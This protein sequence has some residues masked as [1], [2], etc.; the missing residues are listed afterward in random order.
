MATLGERLVGGVGPVELP[1]VSTG[2]TAQSLRAA[3]ENSGITCGDL[4]RR[5]LREAL[6]LGEALSI[7]QEL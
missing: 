1:A 3:Q 5:P 7:L 2:T 6:A 4:G